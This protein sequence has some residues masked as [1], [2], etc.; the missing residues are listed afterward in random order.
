[1]LRGRFDTCLWG[2]ADS[3]LTTG[4]CRFESY[5]AGSEGL[6][7]WACD[8]MHFQLGIGLLLGDGILICSNCSNTNY[9]VVA[10]T[11]YLSSRIT[12]A[13]VPQFVLQKVSRYCVETVSSQQ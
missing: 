10:R 13:Q 11:S 3:R 12:D 1:M 2:V 4:I 8:R 5:F 7:I 6:L 9:S